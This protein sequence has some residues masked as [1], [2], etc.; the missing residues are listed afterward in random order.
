[1]DEPNVLYY[2]LHDLMGK[3]SKEEMCKLMV[4]PGT[5]RPAGYGL[6]FGQDSLAFVLFSQAIMQLKEDG[7][8]NKIVNNASYMVCRNNLQL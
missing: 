6:A 7:T 4:L 1:M 3:V 5:F 8:I 2:L